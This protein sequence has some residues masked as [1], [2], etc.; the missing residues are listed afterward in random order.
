MFHSLALLVT[1][2]GTESVFQVC[3]A[4]GCDRRNVIRYIDEVQKSDK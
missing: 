4:G 3:D 1:D 2:N